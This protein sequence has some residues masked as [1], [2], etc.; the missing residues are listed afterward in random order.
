MPRTLRTRW[1]PAAR[2]TMPAPMIATSHALSAVSGTDLSPSENPVRHSHTY[3]IWVN[4]RVGQKIRPVLE[5]EIDSSERQ[6][7][8]EPVID[9]PAKR[10]RSER[11]VAIVV[12]KRH[13]ADAD[14]R[15][16]V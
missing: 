14:H 10:Q 15:L 9:A 6:F 8:G 12:R 3:A 4:R 16:A 7:A 13:L 5:F 2:P 11:T 1:R